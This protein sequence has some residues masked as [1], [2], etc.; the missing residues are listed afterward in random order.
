MN[1]V[2]AW[3]GAR[4]SEPITYLGIAAFSA[5]CGS[6]LVAAGCQ[7]AGLIVGAIGA[8]FGGVGAFIAKEQ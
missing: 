4:L 2:W 7:K 1:P 5:S 6:A 8:G 3:L